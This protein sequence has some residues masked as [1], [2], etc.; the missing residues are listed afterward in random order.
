MK[1]VDQ[2]ILKNINTYLADADTADSKEVF[3]RKLDRLMSKTP[4]AR[5]SAFMRFGNILFKNNKFFLI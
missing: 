5:T 3:C 4:A 2:T 1:I